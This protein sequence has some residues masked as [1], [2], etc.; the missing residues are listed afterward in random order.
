MNKSS[1][2][3]LAIYLSIAIMSIFLFIVLGMSTII[4]Q[5]LKVTKRIGDS[6]AAF[7]AADTGIERSLYDSK[8]CTIINVTNGEKC[9]NN[10]EGDNDGNG[11]CD[12]IKNDYKT[13]QINLGNGEKYEA[14]FSGGGFQSKGTYR[15]TG[16]AIRVERIK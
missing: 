13:G 11:Y 9:P 4:F 10:C 7:Y 3:G 8:Q 14:K 5:Q 15:G 6:V 16:R 2:K 12:G 1:Q